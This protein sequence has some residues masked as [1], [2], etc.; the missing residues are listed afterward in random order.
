MRSW[1]E[2]PDLDRIQVD[3]SADACRA[4]GRARSPDQRAAEE[5]ANGQKQLLT[6]GATPGQKR[7]FHNEISDLSHRTGNS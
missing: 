4:T 2:A 3:A 5:H 7:K 1:C 6:D